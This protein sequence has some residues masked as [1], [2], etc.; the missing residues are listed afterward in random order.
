MVS[1]AVD[2]LVC[3]D[4]RGADFVDSGEQRELVLHALCLQHVVDLF[5]CDGSLRQNGR[6]LLKYF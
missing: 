5:S 6:F 2:Q 4:L 3:F 1:D